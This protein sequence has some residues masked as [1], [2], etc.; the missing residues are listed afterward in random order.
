MSR[1]AKETGGD[2]QVIY[3]TFPSVKKTLAC[4]NSGN[5]DLA[6][7]DST[8]IRLV[9]WHISNYGDINTY[10]YLILIDQTTGKEI[11]RKTFP[12]VNHLDVAKAYP[13]Q[14]FVVNSGFDV[15]IDTIGIKGK[16]VKVISRYAKNANGEGIIDDLHF[17]KVL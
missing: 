8:N 7:V 16:K 1:Y 4:M 10:R 12:S 14:L 2:G 3:Y 13:N 5:L 9:G 17:T 6:Q 15:T 11:K